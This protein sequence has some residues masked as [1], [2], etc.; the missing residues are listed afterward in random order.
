VQGRGI[1]TVQ[2]PAPGS[3]VAPGATCRLTLASPVT[4]APLVRS[5]APPPVRATVAAATKVVGAVRP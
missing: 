3:P 5:A 1:V 4:P 2:A